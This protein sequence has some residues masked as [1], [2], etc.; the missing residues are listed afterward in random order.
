MYKKLQSIRRNH[1]NKRPLPH[2][3]GPSGYSR[4]GFGKRPSP[5]KEVSIRKCFKCNNNLKLIRKANHLR[6]SKKR[7]LLKRWT[8]QVLCPCG[9]TPIHKESIC[10]WR[11]VVDEHHLL[12][13][14]STTNVQLTSNL[15]DINPK[16]RMR[17][18]KD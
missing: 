14:V 13:P 17:I 9:K 11:E 12:F 6:D 10:N 18:A 8:L 4:M 2:G 3:N 5:Q 7:I 15:A 16:K 1:S